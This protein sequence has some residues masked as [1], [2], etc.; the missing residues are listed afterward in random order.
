M[1]EL[2][3]YIANDGTKFDDEQECMDYEK[4]KIINITQEM[5][6]ELN[7]KLE[8]EGCIFR[9]K[10]K[11]YD[12]DSSIGVIRPVFINNKFIHFNTYH[13]IDIDSDGMDF[14]REFLRTK[15]IE[16]ICSD[17]CNGWMTHQQI[18]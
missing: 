11:Y 2:T 7:Q 4:S 1:V 5:C 8:E 10:F 15:G 3:T 14:V 6:E 16:Y 12:T 9:F 18:Y 13:H 17:G